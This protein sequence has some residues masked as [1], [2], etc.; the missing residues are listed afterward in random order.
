[1]PPA[2]RLH[3]TAQGNLVSVQQDGRGNTLILNVQQTNTGA[4][5]ADAVLNGTL[6]LD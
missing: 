4:V 3:A 5:S 2:A 1:M 6:D